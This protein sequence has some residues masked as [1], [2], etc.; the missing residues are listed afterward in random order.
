MPDVLAKHLHIFWTACEKTIY[1]YSEVTG[2]EQ[3]SKKAVVTLCVA[4][5]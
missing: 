3:I 4:Y 1:Y 2:P 5:A